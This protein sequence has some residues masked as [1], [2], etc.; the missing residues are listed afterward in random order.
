[1]LG[2]SARAMLEA[3][4]ADERDPIVLAEMAQ[5][6]MRPKIGYLRLALEGGFD[7]HHALILRLHLQHVDQLSAS[8]DGLDVEVDR[9]MRPFA[10]Q[11]RRLTTIP[12]SA[13]A[14]RK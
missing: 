2:K 6:R 8:I 12:A 10:E 14:P 13:S 11:H 3:L 4:I 1:M 9:L 7:D 5:T